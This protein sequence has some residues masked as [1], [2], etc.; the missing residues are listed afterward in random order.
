MKT[1]ITTSPFLNNCYAHLPN[2]HAKQF[3][4]AKI[5]AATVVTKTTAVI[6]QGS[7]AAASGTGFSAGIELDI[8]A[9]EK[10]L[11]AYEERS[12]ASNLS[13]NNINIKSGNKTSI[14]GSNLN[15]ND[16]ISIEA[17]TTEIVASKDTSNSDTDTQHQNINL[18][19]GTSGTSASVSADSSKS[20]ANQTNY[21]NA[22]LQA[23]N[24]KINTTETTTI[25]GANLNADESLSLKTKNL[26]V[27]SVQNSSKSKSNSQGISAGFGASGITSAGANM[28]NA[29][30][31]SK[32]TLLTSLTGNKVDITVEDET[33]LHFHMPNITP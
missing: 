13:A 26:E 24:I 29:N 17:K 14:Q 19:F 22:T 27:A 20:S 15:A 16:G 3:P 12:V 4:H 28:S 6:A 33:K 7:K 31:N 8:D 30:S 2:P 23:N 10:Q 5:P 32:Q 11:K 9:I 21:T 18:S 1:V 25:I